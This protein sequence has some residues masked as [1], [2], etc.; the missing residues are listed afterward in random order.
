MF[1]A[2]KTL[3]SNVST[4]IALL[5]LIP[6]ISDLIHHV[7]TPGVAGPDKKSAVITILTDTLNFATGK[8]N[9]KLPTDT[10]L[11]YAN[12]IIDTLVSIYNAWGQ[13]LPHAATQ[14]ASAAVQAPA[15]IPVTISGPAGA[16]TPVAPTAVN[17]PAGVMTHVFPSPILTDNNLGGP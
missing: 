5:Q 2:I 9:L 1:T 16:V 3:F 12:T 15:A 17:D 7:E 6:T 10:I 8:L 13:L 4:L 14:T 11:R